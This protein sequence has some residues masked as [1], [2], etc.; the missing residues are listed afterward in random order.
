M[1]TKEVVNALAKAAEGHDLEIRPQVDLEGASIAGPRILAY[2]FPQD[3]GGYAVDLWRDNASEAF[4]IVRA[5]PDLTT[6]ARYAVENAL[7]RKVPKTPKT[8][9]SWSSS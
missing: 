8:V 9:R 7:R 4:E 2:V 5:I 6:A 1:S 3:A